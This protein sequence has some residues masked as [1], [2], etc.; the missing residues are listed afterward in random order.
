MGGCI[1]SIFPVCGTLVISS[2]KWCWWWYI[3][4]VETLQRDA[5]RPRHAEET[6]V[7]RLTE[8]AKLIFPIY[9]RPELFLSRATTFTIL[10]DDSGLWRSWMLLFIGRGEQLH[11]TLSVKPRRPIH[12]VVSISRDCGI[13][14]TRSR[15]DTN[16]KMR[17]FPLLYSG[18]YEI[19]NIRKST[20]WPRKKLIMKWLK[21]QGKL[22]FKI[23]SKCVSF[24]RIKRP[25]FTSVSYTHLDVYK[26]Q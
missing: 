18:A 22:N 4:S 7:L 6:V 11:T 8:R 16:N 12:S 10:A 20:Q 5:V 19:W 26:R 25:W 9:P 2:L 3:S 14:R 13:F 23:F 17:H 21:S 24:S 1:N 15:K